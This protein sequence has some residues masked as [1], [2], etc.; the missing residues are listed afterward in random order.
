MR[1]WAGV[2][3]ISFCTSVHLSAHLYIASHERQWTI[4]HS[5]FHYAQFVRRCQTL[6]QRCLQSGF[7]GLHQTFPIQLA[8]A[9]R[10]AQHDG[11]LQDGRVRGRHRPLQYLDSLDLTISTRTACC[12]SARQSGPHLPAGSKRRLAFSPSGYACS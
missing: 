1:K 6:A 11:N 7:H 10:L 12:K 4:V 9:R 3:A 2:K 5:S 8:Q